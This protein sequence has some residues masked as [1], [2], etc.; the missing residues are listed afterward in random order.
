M[1]WFSFH[2]ECVTALFF[3]WMAIRQWTTRIRE[4]AKTFGSLWKFQLLWQSLWLLRCSTAS[5]LLVGSNFIFTTS[6]S[7][8]AMIMSAEPIFPGLL[9]VNYTSS[10]EIMQH[11]G[12]LWTI[13]P[14][15]VVF[16]FVYT[17]IG[18][19]FTAK[20]FGKALMSMNYLVLEREADLRF[21]MVCWSMEVHSN[22]APPILTA[23]NSTVFLGGLEG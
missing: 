7:H 9:W 21:E 3:S 19:S 17:F 10:A 18:S 20:I 15:L 4:S 8:M 6:S 11:T 5:P 22:Q 13:S 12:V 1:T 2:F 14:T 23:L 16:L